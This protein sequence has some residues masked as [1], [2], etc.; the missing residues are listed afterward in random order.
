MDAQRTVAGR[1][2]SER[3]ASERADNWNFNSIICHSTYAYS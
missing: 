2:A 3:A 1:A